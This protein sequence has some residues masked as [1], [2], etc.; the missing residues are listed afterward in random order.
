MSRPTTDKNA[1]VIVKSDT[2]N[3][4]Q[5]ARAI[6]VGGTGDISVEMVGI[7]SAIVFKAV[8]VGILYIS[9]TR[10]NS[11]NTGATDMVALR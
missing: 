7:G 6:Y 8:P 9:F 11:T 10:V 3:L 2:V 4:A 5:T 1:E